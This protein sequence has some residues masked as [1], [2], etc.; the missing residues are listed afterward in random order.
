[1][2]FFPMLVGAQS[3]GITSLQ[4]LLQVGMSYISVLTRIVVI[5]GIIFFFWGM[6]LFILHAEEEDK[7]EDKKKMLWSIIA[8]T[9]MFAIWG[10]IK[11]FQIAFFGS[12]F[13]G[14]PSGL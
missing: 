7:E 10:I 4:R 1:M 12:I 5:F 13:P 11:F 8:I 14:A 3:G 6:A 9:V 2:L